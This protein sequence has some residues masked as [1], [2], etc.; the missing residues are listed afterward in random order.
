MKYTDAN[1]PIQCFQNQSTWLQ[2]TKT[3]SKPIGILWHDTAA[4]NPELR[5][6]VQPD[7][8]APNKDEMLKLLGKNQYG[9]DWNHIYRHA[10]LNAWIG[11]LADK[12][13]ATVQAGPWDAY[14]WGCGN[15]RLGS[16]NGNVIPG[17][18]T[19][20]HWI[21][22]EICD[23]GYHSKEYFEKAYNE[24]CQLTAYLCKKF[25]I[26]PMSKVKYA[27]I[28][29]PTIL[30]HQDSYRLSLGCDHSDVYT[31][32]RKFGKTMQD[33]RRDVAAILNETPSPSPAPAPVTTGVGDVVSFT[34]STH[35]KS[36]S[37]KIGCVCNPGLA[38]VTLTAK[39]KH[40][41]H[42]VAVPKQGSDVYGWVDASDV[43]P[44]GLPEVVTSIKPKSGPDKS[45]AG[46]Y[47]CNGEVNIR[48]GAGTK[49][50]TY[51]LITYGTMC[52]CDGRYTTVG[53]DKWLYLKAYVNGKV[54]TGYAYGPYFKKVF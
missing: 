20:T 23:D 22:F 24:A 28:E 48:E 16:C 31:W 25:D 38:T 47:Q 19:G 42:L 33:V 44:S 32:F 29:V 35:Y 54:V 51:G 52:Y 4:G 26:D 41:Y 34:G 18:F 46:T 14:P 1:P 27:G 11:L 7:D 9:N 45:V 15:G 5:R 30:C 40:P 37:S 8:N 12:T 49:Y 36:A 39:G 6:Y 17:G 43:K 21:Q 10:G 3:G 13:I 53:S 2:G 50:K